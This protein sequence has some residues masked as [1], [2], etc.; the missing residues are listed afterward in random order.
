MKGEVKDNIN[1]E[2]INDLSNSKLIKRETKIKNWFGEIFNDKYDYLILF[3]II[4][5]FL[6]YLY[7]FIKVGNQPIWW[8]EGDYLSI[9]KELALNR[10]KPEWWIGQT[11][12]RPIALSLFFSLFFKLGFGEFSIRFFSEFLPAIGVIFVTYLL[13]KELFNKKIGIIASIFIATNWVFMF[14]TFRLLTDIPSAFLG[15]LCFFLFIKYDKTKKPNYLYAMVVFGVLSFLVR[16][17]SVL[18]LISILIYLLITRGYKL[19]LDKKMYLALVIGLLILSPLFYFN[20]QRDGDI[21]PALSSYHGENASASTNPFAWD[22][23]TFHLPLFFKVPITIVFIIG[24]LISMQ[25]FL[26]LDIILKQEVKSKNNLLFLLITIFVPLIYIVFGIRAIDARYFIVFAPVLFVLCAFSTETIIKN[27]SYYTNFKKIYPFLLILFIILLIYSPLQTGD[28]F[29]KSRMHSYEEVK[30][31]GIWLK[32]NTNPSAKVITASITQNQYYSERQSYNYFEN[33]T[34]DPFLFT[35]KLDRIKPNYLI[36]SVF[37][38][39]FTPQWILDGSYI[40]NNS[41]RFTPLVKFPQSSE[42]N[43]LVIYK[44]NY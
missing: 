41:E 40:L 23:I 22:T 5:S 26:Y 24:I 11:S 6:L 29:I 14:Y 19:F 25:I 30:Q 9:A 36:V 35:Q 4:A 20:L 1:M 31:G 12:L 44:V 13:G 39:S 8:D 2:R 32:E 38:P 15:T 28:Q 37:E 7:Y 3:V 43:Y 18:V 33:N 27:I 17:L 10:E 42:A 34:K 21:F 16:Y